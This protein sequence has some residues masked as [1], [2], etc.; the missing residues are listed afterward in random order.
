MRDRTAMNFRSF[1]LTLLAL[2]CTVPLSAQEATPPVAV[3]EAYSGPTVYRAEV[4]ATYPHDASAFTQGLLWHDGALYES[5]GREGQS[6]VRK[7]DLASGEALQE[8]A[9][10]AD[11]FGEGLALVG[12]DFVSLTWRDGVIHRWDA[13][14]LEHKTSRA[15]YPL[16]GWGLTTS[17]EGLVHSDGSA[18]LRILDPDTYEVRRTIDVTMNGRP[19]RRLNE[20]EMIDGLVYANIWET[21]FIVAIDPADGVVKRLIDLRALAQSVP[22]SGSD[23]VLNGIA[24]DADN[25]RMFVTGKLWPSLF[26]IRLVETDAEV[27]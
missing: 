2:G 21:A 8:T 5:T 18:K 19:L 6:V 25:R 3:E 20:L 10:P 26:E 13:D 4:L 27:R 14:T 17:D 23:A 24:W 1:F 12:G 15:E 9:I 7:V 11:Q 22:A 16:E